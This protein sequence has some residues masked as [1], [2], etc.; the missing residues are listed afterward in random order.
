MSNTDSPDSLKVRITAN[1]YHSF[2]AAFSKDGKLAQPVLQGGFLNNNIEYIECINTRELL[3]KGQKCKRDGSLRVAL[4]NYQIEPIATMGRRFEDYDSIEPILA[5]LIESVQEQ[6][7]FAADPAYPEKYQEHLQEKLKIELIAILNP[8]TQKP[9]LAEY[10]KLVASK[11]EISKICSVFT[12]ENYSTR[13]VPP[14]SGFPIAMQE[15]TLADIYPILPEAELHAYALSWGRACMGGNSTILNGQ[16]FNCNYRNASVVIGKDPGQGKS[17]FMSFVTQAMHLCGYTTSQFDFS[18]SEFGAAAYAR[19]DISWIDDIDPD[20]QSQFYKLPKLKSLI[21][22]GSI[23]ARDLY[24]KGGEV[25]SKMVLLMNA[26]SYNPQDISNMDSGLRSRINFLDCLNNNQLA[27]KERK[28]IKASWDDLC[29]T[30]NTNHTTIAAL[31]MRKSFDYFCETVGIEFEADGTWTQSEDR[32][33]SVMLNLRSQFRIKVEVNYLADLV[34]GIV[35]IC[36]LACFVRESTIKDGE[37]TFGVWKDERFLPSDT[38]VIAIPK[39]ISIKTVTQALLTIETISRNGVGRKFLDAHIMPSGTLNFDCLVRL[40]ADYDNIRATKGQNLY[41]E[42]AKVYSHL[43]SSDG[44]NYP[45]HPQPLQQ[46]WIDNMFD[47]D[48]IIA[49]TYTLLKSDEWLTT[50][51]PKFYGVQTDNSYKKGVVED[52]LY[53]LYQSLINDNRT[54]SWLE[55]APNNKLKKIKVEYFKP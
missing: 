45:R 40:R 50:F 22:G 55:Y 37:F 53:V 27:V 9:K 7:E 47:G 52:S 12:A 24:E 5:A 54:N 4:K 14:L 46:Q 23:Y 8:S 26:N 31:W 3:I 49:D 41:Q 43:M 39:H 2:I 15:L 30:H 25:T 16:R 51:A 1:T 34:R 38:V 13:F 21:S 29:A 28:N 48:T 32:L 36:V 44:H 35:R 18:G 33:E 17:F 20:S 42:N 19:S 6:S 11:N 10:A